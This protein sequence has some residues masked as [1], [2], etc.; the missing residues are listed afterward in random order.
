MATTVL[1][2][3]ARS[4]KSALAL[5][6]AAAFDGP[7][8]LIATGEARDGE[9]AARIEQHR[10]KRPSHWST[11]EEPIEI[12]KALESVADG[13]FVILDCLT[14]WIANL[15]DRGFSEKEINDRARDALEAAVLRAPPVVVVTNEVGS[16]IVPDNPTARAYRDLLGSINSI[17]AN[18]ARRVLFVAAGRVLS[19]KRPEEVFDDVFDR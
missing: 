6:L 19:M 11:I 18:D 13:A 10:R 1:I 14:L 4:G 2:G 17:F 8:A 16:G 15:M 12:A 5:E 3:G 7:V 9:M